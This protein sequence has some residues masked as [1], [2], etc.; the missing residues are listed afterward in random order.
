VWGGEARNTPPRT[1]SQTSNNV[2]MRRRAVACSVYSLFFFFVCCFIPSR[3]RLRHSSISFCRGGGG[4]ARRENAR[5]HPRS[6]A[7]N[8][9]HTRT[10]TRDIRAPPGRTARLRSPTEWPANTC[11]ARWFH[12]K[13]YR[14]VSTPTHHCTRTLLS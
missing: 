4:D 6:S 3:R 8:A 9:T 1:S 12:W 2:E 13:R 10:D 11:S 7:Q 5:A 14:R